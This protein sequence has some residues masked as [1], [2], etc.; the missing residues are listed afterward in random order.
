MSNY[1][2]DANCVS[3]FL[4]LKSKYKAQRLPW[5]RQW[6][7][8]RAA[9]HGTG[10]LDAVYAGRADVRVPII[11]WKVNGITSRIN[12]IMF[13]VPRIGRLEALKKDEAS[14]FVDFHD[15]YIF[16]YQLDA[17]DFKA[18]FK[19]FTHTKV[20][21][22]T[23][24]AKITQEYEER[25]IDYFDSK[26]KESVV[27]KDNTYFRPLLL[28]EFLSDLTKTDIND[29]QA[30]IHSTII[31]MQEI[32][33]NKKRTVTTESPI[34]G[35]NGEVLGVS[36]ETKT[37]GVYENLELLQPSD[38]GVT[39]EQSAYFQALNLGQDS[40]EVYQK[41]LQES[42]KTGHVQIDECYGRYDLDGD[43][44]EE[45]VAV[46]IAHGFI[47]IRKEP[48][49][50]RHRRYVRPFVVGRYIT[51]Q[52]C[53]YGE[54]KVIKGL[55][56]LAELN[57]VRAQ[58]ID[59]RTRSVSPMW[60]KDTQANINWDGV[61]RPNGIVAGQGPNPALTPLLNPY[62]GGVTINDAAVIER[63]LDKLWS[64][65]PVQEGTSS[66]SQIPSTARGTLAV[67]NQNDM[68][69]NEVIDHT[70][71][72][73]KQ[74]IEMLYERNLRFKVL[75]DFISVLGQKAVK[76]ETLPITMAETLA[77]VEVKILGN[78][79]LS[80]EVA[81]QAGLERFLQIAATIP[82]IAKRLDWTQVA[83]MLLRA[84]G[85]KDEVDSIWLDD[86]L[87]AQADQAQNEANQQAEQQRFVKDHQVYEAK[88]TADTQ[89]SIVKMGAEAQIEK[90]TGQKIQ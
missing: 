24:V 70:I 2:Q 7:Q 86:E 55:K 5:E 37:R 44:I 47:I 34:L 68:P 10:S 53:L 41:T 39:P 78:L 16:D 83:D 59:A 25:E 61:W 9:Y 79:E 21:L 33:R 1:S 6:K 90:A 62:L 32:L 60:W 48:S 26:D 88:L 74:F 87:I 42:R 66:S 23:A 40:M 89:A 54:S 63:D 80:N 17:I 69:L 20:L 77:Q 30:C 57:A 8:A 50:F 38:M 51:I 46:T 12:R 22:G 49:P 15:K 73:L 82:P 11:D 13:N 76:I 67:I 18:A 64:L 29:S 14:R 3:Y 52:N 71:E 65:S 4:S 72:E 28:E 56:L 85:L 84:Y 45:E 81:H 43:G 19:L 36:S 75:D 58:A 27:V 31:S 35:P